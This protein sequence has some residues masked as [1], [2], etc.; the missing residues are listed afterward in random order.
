MPYYYEVIPLSQ[1]NEGLTYQSNERIPLG[2]IVQIPLRKKTATGV[3]LSETKIEN[4]TF[5]VKKILKIQKTYTHSI[6]QEN[7]NFYQ[8]L[9]SHYFID[10]GMVFK[11]A[12]QQYPDT[13]HK[14]FF[15]YKGKTFSSQKDLTNTFEL[16]LKQFKEL[17]A[18]KEIS[19]TSKNFLFHQMQK[20]IKL[21]QE[22]QK[23]FDDIWHLSLI[24][25]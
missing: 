11:I 5:D 25:I 17:L 23:I 18:S 21:N 15:S 8:Y 1:I 3:I 16:K 7:L 20:E 19:L 2:S 4:I 12:I 10:L 9:S 6:N 13:Q 14:S 24:H 22:Q